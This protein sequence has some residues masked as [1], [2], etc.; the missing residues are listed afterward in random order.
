MKKNLN[1][2]RELYNVL[3]A[4][5]GNR[6]GVLAIHSRI[7]DIVYDR[8]GVKADITLL[9]GTRIIGRLSNKHNF[10]GTVGNANYRTYRA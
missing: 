3:L 2:S 8:W 1:P 10:N 9:D 7:N 5:Y 4:I 6:C